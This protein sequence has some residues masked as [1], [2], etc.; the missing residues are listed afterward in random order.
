MSTDNFGLAFIQD[1]V[2]RS[3]GR[4]EFVEHS[5]GEGPFLSLTNE[6]DPTV[7]AGY[8]RLWSAA[9]DSRIDRMVH[10]RL[11]SDPVDTQLFFLFGRP[12]SVMPHFH[13]QVVQFSPDACVFNADWIAR[14][15]PVEHPDYYEQVFW[16]INKPYWKAINDRENVCSMA[17]ASPAIAAFLSPWS[18]G[19]GRPT[20]KNE[21]ERVGPH[22]VAFLE[23]GLGLANDLEYPAPDAAAMAER[24]R[25]HLECF[26]DDK[27]D[28]R[29]W[30]G[31][32]KV[33]GEETGRRVKEIFKTSLRELT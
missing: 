7:G 2:E 32:Y 12:G 14:L 18:I 5:G 21:L 29:A 31:V 3:L 25:K 20:D 30:N 15:D 6:A 19:A 22:I 11:Q 28:P 23:H 9:D 17:P 10:F 27:L 16:P 26:F 1:L 13:A 4:L 8:L 33:I 24:D